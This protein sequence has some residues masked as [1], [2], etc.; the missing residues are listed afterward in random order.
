MMVSQ[1]KIEER[2]R[3]I[4]RPV[5]E[6]MDSAR[7]GK[8]EKEVKVSRIITSD[9]GAQTE[10]DKTK[11]NGEAQ[12]DRE[13]QIER[14]PAQA[15]STLPKSGFYETILKSP[16]SFSKGSRRVPLCI[17]FVPFNKLYRSPILQLKGSNKITL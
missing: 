3:I 4:E 10:R 9:V 7:Q 14:E 5:E 17:L 8:V 15:E 13:S 16:R 12:T 6:A 11:A 1:K 2:N